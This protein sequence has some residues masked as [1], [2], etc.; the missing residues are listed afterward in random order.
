MTP[1]RAMKRVLNSPQKAPIGALLES[2]S[3]SRISILY[4]ARQAKEAKREAQAKELTAQGQSLRK[5]IA[6]LRRKVTADWD[7]EAKA[8]VSRSE[9]VRS[10]LEKMVRRTG[11]RS[12][13]TTVF[14]RAL[15]VVTTV[16]KLT[17]RVL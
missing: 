1:K 11:K 13:N 15:D 7:Q 6:R 16:L 2:L 10:R 9:S 4:L 12:K 5:E 3:E 14:T 17:K 8:L